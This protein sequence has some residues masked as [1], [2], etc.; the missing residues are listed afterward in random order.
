[1]NK[2]TSCKYEAPQIEVIYLEVEKGFAL[3]DI[4][5]DENGFNQ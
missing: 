3:S 4:N 5:Y 2:Q 1:M